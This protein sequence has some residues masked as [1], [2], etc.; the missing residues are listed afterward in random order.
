[1]SV[2][3]RYLLMFT[4]DYVENTI[5]DSIMMSYK[6]PQFAAELLSHCEH[7]FRFWVEILYV[8]YPRI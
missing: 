6:V 1:M 5:I 8:Q 3:G 4:M 7:L 2:L